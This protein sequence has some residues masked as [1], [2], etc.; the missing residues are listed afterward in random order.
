MRDSARRPEDAS[1]SFAPTVTGKPPRAAAAK[2]SPRPPQTRT[3]TPATKP[4]GAGAND[5]AAGGAVYLVVGF[6]GVLLVLLLL[7]LWTNAGG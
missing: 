6:V 1:P 5:R 3:K 2:R 7:W 4:T